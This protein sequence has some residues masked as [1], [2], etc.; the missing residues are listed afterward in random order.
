MDSGSGP[1]AGFFRSCPPGIWCTWPLNGAQPLILDLIAAVT[2]NHRTMMTAS[3]AIASVFR[4]SATED[5]TTTVAPRNRRPHMT[6]YPLEF[7]R[8][9]EQKW[10]RR[11][12]LFWATECSGDK[13][14]R[15]EEV[16]ERRI[17]PTLAGI[18][19]LALLLRGAASL[20][21]SYVF[22][23]RGHKHPL[24]APIIYRP[25]RAGNI[26]RP[27]RGR[28]DHFPSAPRL[29][30]PP[31]RATSIMRR[32]RHHLSV[33]EVLFDHLVGAGQQ[34]GATSRPSN[35]A[36]C[37]LMTNSNLV[38]CTTGRSAGFS[39]LR[40]RSMYVAAL[41]KPPRRA[42]PAPFK[43]AVA[44]GRP[45]HLGRIRQRR[46]WPDRGRHGLQAV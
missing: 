30:G 26:G 31:T 16:K 7:H 20:F 18:E 5:G 42:L 9:F 3:T 14:K 24:L 11:G 15:H 43:G 8:R 28:P 19:Q 4:Y 46:R 29:G 25:G 33:C 12:Q 34:R 40:M 37:R 45:R 36:V 38:A 21:S 27:S 2:R 22:A 39:P 13:R 1:N 41:A 17:V 23:V 35:L 44:A 6:V 32:A 10:A